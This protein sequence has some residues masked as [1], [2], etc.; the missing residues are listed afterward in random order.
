M[1]HPQ[2]PVIL[3]QDFDG[4]KIR[5]YELECANAQS[6]V[7]ELLERIVAAAHEKKVASYDPQ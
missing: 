7:R 3:I 6:K 2:K 1:S 4:E 5:A